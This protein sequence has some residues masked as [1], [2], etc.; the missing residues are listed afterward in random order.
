M[1]NQELPVSIATR[2]PATGGAAG[3][4]PPDIHEEQFVFEL[5]NTDLAGSWMDDV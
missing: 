5:S 4:T 3:E 2:A 1:R